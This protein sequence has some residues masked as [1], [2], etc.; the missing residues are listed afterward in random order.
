[1]PF[2]NFLRKNEK[3]LPL[4]AERIVPIVD[5][6]VN[7][8]L[9]E[10]NERLRRIEAKQKETGLHLEEIDGFLQGDVA[11]DAAETEKALVEALIALADTIG[12]FYYFA[13]QGNHSTVD[14]PDEAGIAWHPSNETE[15]GFVLVDSE[16]M[17]GDERDDAD[18]EDAP[19][20]LF[21]QAQMMW[22]AAKSAAENAGLEVIDAGRE[23]FDFRI[24]SA[25]SVE[26]DEGLP[27]GYVI[28][29]LKCG[30][31]YKDEVV[32]RAAVV[33]NKTGASSVAYQEEEAA[34]ESR[35]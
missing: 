25:E 7:D 12:D 24:H 10:I 19:S 22:N 34:D 29:T 8:N 13:G 15:R 2:L 18:I 1:M 6:G 31:V 27:N 35:D 20:P 23:P 26:R 11:A 9:A 14:P 28:K 5:P 30:Y 32:R 4:P 16:D 17:E 21:E 3:P 33:V